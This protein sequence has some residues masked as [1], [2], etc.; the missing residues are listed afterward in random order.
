ML[1][2]RSISCFSVAGDRLPTV[3]PTIARMA[4]RIGRIAVIRLKASA[5][6]KFI[7]QSLL[8]L[9]KNPMN[10]FA[11][12]FTSCLASLAVCCSV[13]VVAIALLLSSPARHVSASPKNLY[14]TTPYGKH[15]SG[16]C[17]GSQ[18]SHILYVGVG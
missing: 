6:A 14:S 8:N 17:N 9:L 16:S 18:G 10:D 1:L 15:E 12:C 13:V 3:N 2:K 7:T 5:E 11:P 4:I